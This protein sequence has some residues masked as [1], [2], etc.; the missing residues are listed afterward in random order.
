MAVIWLLVSVGFIALSAAPT[1]TDVRAMGSDGEEKLNELDLE[2]LQKG[3]IVLVSGSSFSKIIPGRWTHAMMYIGDG[4]II[5]SNQ[6]GVVINDAKSIYDSEKAAIFRVDVSDEIKNEAVNFALK[7]EGKPYDVGW[8]TKQVHGESYYCSEL[9]WASYK[10]QG[11]EIDED[12]GW[13]WTYTYGVAPTELADDDRTTR[14]A[15]SS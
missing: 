15:Y 8:V 1:T 5:E 13:S 12:P 9:A 10:T 3:D 2:K 6:N 7:Q 11:I 14:I 4:R